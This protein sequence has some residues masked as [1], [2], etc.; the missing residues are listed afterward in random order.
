MLPSSRLTTANSF[1][2]DNQSIKQV[3]LSL[4]K[5]K[6][7]NQVVHFFVITHQRFFSNSSGKPAKLQLSIQF[8]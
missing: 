6:F 5:F 8:H 2:C 4:S 7:K 3:T 1:I